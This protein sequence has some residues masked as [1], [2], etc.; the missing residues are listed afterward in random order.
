VQESEVGHGAVDGG[1]GFGGAAVVLRCHWVKC[2]G[3]LRGY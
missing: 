2:V 3:P 1:R